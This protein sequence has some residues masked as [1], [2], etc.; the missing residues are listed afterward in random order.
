MRVN[1]QYSVELEDL[2]GELSELHIR[3]NGESMHQ[4]YIGTQ[5]LERMLE[6]ED[7]KGSQEQIETIR[8][9]LAVLDITLSEI[10]SMLEGCEI[11]QA[12]QLLT[13]IEETDEQFS[14][15]NESGESG[16]GL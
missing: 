11:V 13:Q 16:Q 10:G 12:Q 3:K 1:L 8:T 4:I 14:E 6:E 5:S 7:L 15:I 2:F 9:Q